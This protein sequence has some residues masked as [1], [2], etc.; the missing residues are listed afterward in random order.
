[1]SQE[2]VDVVRRGFEHFRATG[3]FLPELVDPEFVWD[4]SSF[5]GWPEQKAYPGLEGAR[6]FMQD[7]LSAWEDWELEVEALHDAG[8]KVVAIVRQQGRSKT[9][10]LPVNMSFGQVFTVRDGKQTLMQMYA[11]PSQALEASGLS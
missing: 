3:D 1:M 11:D 8:D 4:M 2:N 10:G 9:T 6:Q 7:W 5:R